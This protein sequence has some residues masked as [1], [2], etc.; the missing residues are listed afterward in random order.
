MINKTLSQVDHAGKSLRTD[1]ALVFY[2]VGEYA[3]DHGEA[4]GK[5]IK[6]LLGDSAQVASGDQGAAAISITRER[7]GSVPRSIPRP[8]NARQCVF[9]RRLVSETVIDA[10]PLG[11]T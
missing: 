4:L 2:I 10:L 11:D 5:P 8:C 1:E 9:E 7:A 3:L 6:G